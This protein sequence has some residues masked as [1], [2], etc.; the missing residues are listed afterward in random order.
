V[1][2]SAD[3]PALEPAQPVDPAEAAGLVVEATILRSVIRRLAENAGVPA[4]MLKA[5]AE[6]RQ[7]VATLCAVLR[8]ERALAPREEDAVSATLARALEEL[9]DE[10]EL[11]E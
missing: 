10:V 1:P 9:G 6:L 5:W 7:Q 2:R 11:P 4:P 3:R 8:T